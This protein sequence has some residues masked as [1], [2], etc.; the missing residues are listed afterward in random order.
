MTNGFGPNKSKV[1]QCI[2][3]VVIVVVTGEDKTSDIEDLGSVLLP[4]L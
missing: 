2:V 3:V 1:S 4:V